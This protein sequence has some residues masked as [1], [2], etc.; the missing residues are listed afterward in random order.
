MTSGQS[1]ASRCM[2]S[3]QSD[4]SRCMTSGQSD[5]SRRTAQESNDVFRPFKNFC[6][7][8]SHA[9]ALRHSTFN[10]V[11][12]KM[13]PES[14][15]VKYLPKTSNELFRNKDNIV[16]LKKWIADKLAGIPTH[17][18]V[19]L[20]GKT[21]VGKT[22]LLK[23]CFKECNCSA[24][25][26]DEEI[27]S[28]TFEILM[29]TVL[30]TNVENLLSGNTIRSAV[31]IDNYQTTLL[32]GSRKDLIDSLKTKKTCPVVFTSITYTNITDLIRSKGL[33]I[34][35]E[36][37]TND[38][39]LSF[40]NRIIT[41]ESI[42]LDEDRARELVISSYG[43]IRSLLNSIELLRPCAN[44]FTLEKVDL[45]LDVQ[46]T[47]SYLVSQNNPFKDKIRQTSLYTSHLIQENYL[48]MGM[49]NKSS[50]EHISNAADWCSFGNEMKQ[51]I[52][53]TQS[54]DELNDVTNTVA[55]MGPI[56]SLHLKG[57]LPITIKIPN[58]KINTLPDNCL[59]C[60]YTISD[61]SYILFNIYA[62]PS[63]MDRTPI[64]TKLFQFID[65]NKMDFDIIF[66]II[67]NAYLL[68]KI[69]SKDIKRITGKIK[70]QYQS[71]EA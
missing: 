11:G 22:E 45:E 8:E 31:I 19:L 9:P 26:Y 5:A 63:D 37:P 21:G 25:E 54:W 39:L 67:N 61:L 48:E 51:F 53:Q 29:Q 10:F 18:F 69:P 34:Y 1:D 14:I 35:F 6:T 66:K 50:L 57:K 17:P 64:N 49:K 13:D 41:T 38:D 62:R 71:H 30:S 70:K 36:N 24:I 2:T 20:V 47:F 55:T 15:Y 52:F 42:Q 59:Y 4:A 56:H 44:T 46:D 43:N 60:G 65:D 28:N 7:D 27:R 58:R 68:N 23:T 40:A 3:G 33:V 32:S 12:Q 16:T